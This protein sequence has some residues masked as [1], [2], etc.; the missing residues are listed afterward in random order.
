[1]ARARARARGEDYNMRYALLTTMPYA[2]RIA[3]SLGGLGK[4]WIC[5]VNVKETLGKKNLNIGKNGKMEKWKK[6]KHENENLNLKRKI[7]KVTVRK[8]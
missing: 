4:V 5:G 1:V 7:E 6:K 2:L 8:F 3:H